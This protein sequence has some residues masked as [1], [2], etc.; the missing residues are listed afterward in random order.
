MKNDDSIKKIIAMGTRAED[1]K[2]RLLLAGVKEDII[3]AIPNEGDA[4]NYL[5]YD[6][7]R[8]IYILYDMYEEPIVDRVNRKIKEKIA[9]GEN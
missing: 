2:L 5:S 6:K 7:D 3:V 9:G 8:S 1:L 4:E